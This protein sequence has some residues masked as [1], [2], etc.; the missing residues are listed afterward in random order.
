MTDSQATELIRQS[1][2]GGKIELGGD[3]LE[4]KKKIS[5]EY[6]ETDFLNKK[7]VIFERKS[8]RM[9]FGA[10]VFDNECVYGYDCGRQS[11]NKMKRVQGYV[12][13]GDKKTNKHP[14][15]FF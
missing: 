12:F 3:W 11:L 5:V 14:Q 1:R 4:F 13:S 10:F 15:I 7:L 6:N 8:D 9:L 2:K